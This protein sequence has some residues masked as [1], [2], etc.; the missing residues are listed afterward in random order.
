MRSC[1]RLNSKPV[2]EQRR[3][4]WW[5]HLLLLTTS[6][7]EPSVQRPSA[8]SGGSGDNFDGRRP[9][10]QPDDVVI[11][12]EGVLAIV[13]SHDVWIA[14]YGQADGLDAENWPDSQWTGVWYPGETGLVGQYGDLDRAANDALLYEKHPDS[15]RIK[16]LLHGLL[17]RIERVVAEATSR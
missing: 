11:D 14:R 8:P 1:S 9:V 4:I 3:L 15:E 17:D 16:A 10:L 13:L 5:P 2:S 12:N 6:E 7:D